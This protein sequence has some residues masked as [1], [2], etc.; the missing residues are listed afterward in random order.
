MYNTIFHIWHVET[1]CATRVSLTAAH[2]I[3]IFIYQSDFLT[4]GDIFVIS[5][6]GAGIVPTSINTPRS[7]FLAPYNLCVTTALQEAHKKS[8]KRPT[9]K[10]L[11]QI[12]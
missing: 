6:F 8:G 10:K 12:G 2:Q 7:F 9:V 4:R 3:I 1:F 5:I 11:D